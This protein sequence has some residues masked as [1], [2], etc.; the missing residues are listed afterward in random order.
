M[1]KIIR[2][3]IKEQINKIDFGFL[4]E[5]QI[6]NFP[7]NYATIQNML[8]KYDFNK[9]FRT[10]QDGESIKLF[11]TGERYLIVIRT[12]HEIFSAHISKDEFFKLK[13]LI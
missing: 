9:N 6:I 12:N 11:F 13:N 10:S 7:G 5:E 3:V 8:K 2:K 1:K 4:N